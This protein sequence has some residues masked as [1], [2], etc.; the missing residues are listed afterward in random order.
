MDV[1]FLTVQA[2]TLFLIIRIAWQAH[3]LAWRAQPRRSLVHLLL[4]SWVL[5]AITV[6]F[7][8]IFWVVV[9]YGGRFLPGFAEYR[10]F[11]IAINACGQLVPAVALTF[12]WKRLL[13]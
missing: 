4:V 2:V 10:S 11:L 3:T 6:I 13:Q 9:L 7:N 1:L 5:W 8:T 12:I